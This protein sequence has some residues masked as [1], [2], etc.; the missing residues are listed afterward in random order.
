MGSGSFT[1][2]LLRA[3]DGAAAALRL[4]QRGPEHLRTGNQGEDEAY[5][6]LRKRGYTVIARNWRTPRRKGELDIVAWDG[7]TLCF[8]EVK[9]RSKKA[10]VP[11]EAA[12]DREKQ[13]EL[14]AMAHEFLKMQKM[15]AQFRFDVIAVYMLPGQQAEIEILKDVLR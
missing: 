6:F 1:R 8:V 9:T 15:A 11:A 10:F 5:F 3:L 14:R 2:V 4:A 13:R 7:P 12:V